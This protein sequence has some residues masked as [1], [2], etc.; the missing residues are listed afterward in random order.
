M[1]RFFFTVGQKKCPFG[2]IYCFTEFEDYVR[3]PSI[4]SLLNNEIIID[5]IDIIYP[6][7]DIDFF[8]LSNWRDILNK[9]SSYN[10]TI[11]ISTKAKLKKDD[12]QFIYKIYKKIIANG[13]FLKIGISITTKYKDF[14]IEPKTPSYS[15]RLKVIKELS[16]IGVP[17]CLIMKP[18]LVDIR[19]NELNSIVKDFHKFCNIILIG[20]EYVNMDSPRQISFPDSDTYETVRRKV[21]WKFNNDDWLARINTLQQNNLKKIS[22]K[23]NLPIVDNDVDVI[24]YLKNKYLE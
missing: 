23:Y 7:C 13:G 9:I 18:L 5:N 12:I 8:C 10:K 20:D 1:N 15:E 11:A 4:Y 2:C 21:N 19:T 14:K 6:A 16:E 3:P 17:V 24:K 22:F